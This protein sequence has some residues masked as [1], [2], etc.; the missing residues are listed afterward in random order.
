MLFLYLDSF[1]V[2]KWLTG[3]L[4]D[5]INLVYKRYKK[6]DKEEL[7]ELNYLTNKDNKTRKESKEVI[8]LKK[9]SLGAS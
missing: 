5:Y 1:H 6:R 3:A 4:N 2:L 9:I 7:D 8:L